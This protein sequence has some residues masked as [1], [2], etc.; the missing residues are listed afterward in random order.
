MPASSEGGDSRHLRSDPKSF[1]SETLP[2]ASNQTAGGTRRG[3]E[4]PGFGGREWHGTQ[5]FQPPECRRGGESRDFSRV[6]GW[7]QES[8]DRRSDWGAKCQAIQVTSLAVSR[9]AT[10]T[11]L[12]LKRIFM[13]QL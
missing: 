11:M 3:P 5:A 8:K 4:Q 6:E 7:A 9:A 12:F 13:I 2:G 1:F 10:K